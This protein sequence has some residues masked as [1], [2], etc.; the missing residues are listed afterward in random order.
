MSFQEL[1]SDE[2]QAFERLRLTQRA[3]LEAQLSAEL[4]RQRMAITRQVRSALEL[5]SDLRAEPEFISAPVWATLYRDHARAHELV[6]RA[7]PTLVRLPEVLSRLEYDLFG[8][9]SDG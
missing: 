9:R 8:A 3:L 5:D 2:I 4:G 6:A 7:Q 1:S